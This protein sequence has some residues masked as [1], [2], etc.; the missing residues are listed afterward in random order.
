MLRITPS[1]MSAAI[2]SLGSAM[3]STLTQLKQSVA[4]LFRSSASQPRPAAAD[5]GSRQA[6]VVAAQTPPVRRESLEAAPFAPSDQLPDN[7]SYA[8]VT[9]HASAN[10][11][12]ALRPSGQAGS[13]REAWPLDTMSTSMASGKPDSSGVMALKASRLLGTDRNGE[14]LTPAQLAADRAN[15]AARNADRFVDLDWKQPSSPTWQPTKPGYVL[16]MA[17][18]FIDNTSVENLSGPKVMRANVKAETG[19]AR[20]IQHAASK[21]IDTA[22]DN[23]LSALAD[24]EMPDASKVGELAA[25][26]A[27]IALEE[28]SARAVSAAFVE[29]AATLPQESKDMLKQVANMLRDKGVT[30]FGDGMSVRQRVVANLFIL[31]SVN[32]VVMG[33]AA[34]IQ[35]RVADRKDDKA[36]GALTSEQAREVALLKAMGRALQVIGGSGNMKSVAVAPTKAEGKQATDQEAARKLAVDNAA[37]EDLLKGLNSTVKELSKTVLAASDTMLA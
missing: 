31:K 33:R 2:R 26:K 25:S 20:Y 11:D 24:V 35:N 23:A 12:I 4:R 37:F 22:I 15:V 13:G 10:A 17:Q 16:E 3:G 19:V 14:D 7:K 28:A 21:E 5:L 9:F 34:K 27:Q 1:E 36:A 30:D 6:A 18:K 8:P 32:G 29:L